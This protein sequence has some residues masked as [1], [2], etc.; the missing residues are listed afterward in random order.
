M[1]INAAGNIGI[2]TQSPEAKLSIV[3]DVSAT[4]GLSAAAGHVGASYFG[5]CVGIGTNRPNVNA[6]LT[7]FRS[8]DQIR[9][10]DGSLAYFLGYDDSYFRLKNSAGDTQ[11]VTNWSSGNVGIGTATPGAKLSVKGSMSATGGLSAA[12]V[13]GTSYFGGNVGIGT[14][15]PGEAINCFW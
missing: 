13:A 9:L 5:S 2:G 11:F 12:A 14:N 6:K 1:Y 3:G 7:V 8:N 10:E 4:G 15:H